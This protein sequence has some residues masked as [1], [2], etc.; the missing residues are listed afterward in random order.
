MG[1]QDFFFFIYVDMP[2]TKNKLTRNLSFPHSYVTCLNFYP[3]VNMWQQMYAK[4][5][6]L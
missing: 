5:T 2:A 1:S 4:N 6:Y 3:C